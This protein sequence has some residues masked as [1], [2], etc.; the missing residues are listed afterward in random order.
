MN[1]RP[2]RNAFRSWRKPLVKQEQFNTEKFGRTL[3]EFR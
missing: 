3:A 2:S 1:G